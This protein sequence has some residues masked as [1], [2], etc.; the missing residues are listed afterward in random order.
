MALL[1][2]VALLEEAAEMG[3]QL[4]AEDYHL[5]ESILNSF[6]D[7]IKLAFLKFKDIYALTQELFI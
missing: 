6:Q 3:H 2:V 5:K 7:Q 1:L 4:E